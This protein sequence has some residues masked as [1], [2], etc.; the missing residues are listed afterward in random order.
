MNSYSAYLDH[1]SF[2]MASNRNGWKTARHRE[3]LTCRAFLLCSGL[4]KT[5]NLSL[6]LNQHSILFQL[7]QNGIKQKG[8]K[9]FY[10]FE[11]PILF[12]DHIH[13]NDNKKCITQGWIAEVSSTNHANLIKRYKTN[14][15]KYLKAKILIEW[16]NIYIYLSNASMSKVENLPL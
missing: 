10:S 1:F 8:R 13:D 15:A 11:W 7:F 16:E 6:V 9:F 3:I 12:F 14:F 4:A 2:K 5:N